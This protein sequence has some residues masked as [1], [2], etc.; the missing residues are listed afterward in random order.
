MHTITLS[1][2][3][4]SS[5]TLS[6]QV[7]SGAPSTVTSAGSVPDTANAWYIDQNNV[8]PYI[9]SYVETV[10]ATEVIKYQPT[11]I[12]SGTTLPNIDSTGLYPGV[13]NWG[14][15]SVANDV[16]ITYGALTAYNST[17]YSGT[18]AATQGYQ[19]PVIPEPANWYGNNSNLANLPLYGVFLGIYQSTGIPVQTLYFIIMM[20][21]AFMLFFF[22]VMK[23][24]SI[25]ISGVFLV[26]LLAMASGTGVIPGWIVYVL[27]I[28]SIGVLFL[29]RQIG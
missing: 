20:L 16:T 5:G 1:E 26:V 3:T 12:I 7:D 13:I 24:H 19:L 28:G 23:T 25:M 6:L 14:L 8:M 15:D 2:T 9:T 22:T 18:V 10:G 29:A 11:V 17:S 27:A 4:A 21:T